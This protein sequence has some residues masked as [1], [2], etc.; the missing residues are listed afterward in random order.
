MSCGR[1]MDK[2][3]V[4]YI[5]NGILFSLRTRGMGTWHK[6]EDLRGEEWGGLDE[7]R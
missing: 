7:R 2:E 1:W 6:L 4:V 5:F 3:K